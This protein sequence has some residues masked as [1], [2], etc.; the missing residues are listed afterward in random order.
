VEPTTAD[1]TRRLMEAGLKTPDSV[2]LGITNH[3]NL[4]CRHCWPDS[5]PDNLASM[6]PRDRVVKL[7]RGFSALGAAKFT[8]TGG[9]P[10]THPEWIDLLFFACGLPEVTEVRLQTNGILITPS[11]LEVFVSLKDRGLIVQMSLEGVTPAVHDRIRGRG[12]FQKTLQGL[13]LLL[14]C[15]LAAHIC[16]AFTEMQHN[17]EELPDLL[18][19]ID[20]MGIGQLVSG[21]LVCDGRARQS[22][23]LKP[24]VPQQYEKLIA[25][26]QQDSDFRDRYKRIGNVAAL[27]WA[28]AEPDTTETCC[29]LIETP[30]VTAKGKLYPC[31]LLQAEKYAAT[32]VFERSLAVAISEKIDSWARLL[33][34][35]QSRS[36]DLETCRNCV[37]YVRCRGGCMGRAYAAHG[38]FFSVEDRCFLRK[39]IYRKR[40]IQKEMGSVEEN[41]GK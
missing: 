3:C 38:D 9:E 41:D 6:V 12:S 17:F 25:R 8:I 28:L 37:G 35:S 36:T 16:I 32:Q 10:L 29:T 19:M 2:T 21:T 22:D 20:S 7:I 27:E 34:I 33:Q 4:N 15:G 30:Y 18:E 1:I 5:G 40:V 13:E 23:D 39:T 24:P 14:E 26:Y 11:D 31:V